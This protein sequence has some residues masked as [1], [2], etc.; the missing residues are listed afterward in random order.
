MSIST[1]RHGDN[2]CPYPHGDMETLT[3]SCIHLEDMETL[4]VHIHIYHMETLHVCIYMETWRHSMSVSRW[5]HGHINMETLSML[6]STWRH[7]D[8]LMETC[9]CPYPH[10]DMET[11][12]TW[13]H[14]VSVSTWKHGDIPCPYPHGDMETLHVH[15]HMETWR[16]S[17]SVSTWSHM[18]TLHVHI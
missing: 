2:P 17:V 4:H 16:H 1:W 7:G 5:G 10:G 13:K 11:L 14:S 3:V 6:V 15:I 12:D 18:E 8:T 9:P